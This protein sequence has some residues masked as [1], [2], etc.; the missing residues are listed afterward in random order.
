MALLPDRCHNGQLIWTYV[1]PLICFHI[2]EL[3]APDRVLRQFGMHQLLP[4]F[5]N[6][7]PALHKIDL[8]GKHDQDWSKIH[9]KYITMWH[10]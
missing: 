1:G 7:N 4:S 9:A 5:C 6:T 3:H 2:V 8:R 10:S